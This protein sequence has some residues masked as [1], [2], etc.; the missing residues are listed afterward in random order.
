MTIKTLLIFQT[1]PG[2]VSTL[3]FPRETFDTLGEKAP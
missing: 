2:G 1:L 3:P